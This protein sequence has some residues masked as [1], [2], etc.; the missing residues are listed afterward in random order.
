L[1]VARLRAVC[2]RIGVTEITVATNRGATRHPIARISG[3]RLAASAQARLHRL[4]RDSA[5]REGLDQLIVPL[6]SPAGAAR[7]LQALL[8]G[9]VPAPAETAG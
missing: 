3:L 1:D 7:A 2:L 6:A 4:A 8:E 9:L 5:Y